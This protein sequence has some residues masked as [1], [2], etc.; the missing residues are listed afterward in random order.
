MHVPPAGVLLYKGMIGH[1]RYL[2]WSAAVNGYLRDACCRAGAMPGEKSPAGGCIACACS[3]SGHGKV[4]LVILVL[5]TACVPQ[6]VL[7]KYVG[8]RILCLFYTQAY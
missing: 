1:Q 4:F 3:A 8:F 7:A 2:V 5:H 6:V